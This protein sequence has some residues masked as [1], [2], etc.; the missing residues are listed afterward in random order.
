MGPPEQ[1]STSLPPKITTR[2]ARQNSASLQWTASHLSLVALV[3]LTFQASCILPT[4]ET[5]NTMDCAHTDMT[6]ALTE[7]SDWESGA[8]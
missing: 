6:D 5:A 4:A 8:G 7:T 1:I 2:T 3:R